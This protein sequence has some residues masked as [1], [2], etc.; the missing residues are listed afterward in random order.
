MYACAIL[1]VTVWFFSSSLFCRKCYCWCC[2]CDTTVHRI[3]PAEKARQIV[4]ECVLS[5]DCAKQPSS[6]DCIL[7]WDFLNM[8]MFVC[9]CFRFQMHR[10]DAV[11]VV[12]ASNCA[13]FTNIRADNLCAAR[14]S[15][16]LYKTFQF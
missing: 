2:C 7:N 9:V 8:N 11:A 13:D 4:N 14:K 15:K 6:F 1:C 3:T 12:A 10:A 5:E 16:M